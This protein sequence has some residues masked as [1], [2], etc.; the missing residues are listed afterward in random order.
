MLGQFKCAPWVTFNGD[1]VRTGRRALRA[2]IRRSREGPQLPRSGPEPPRYAEPS[3]PEAKTKL[4]LVC[5]RAP[6]EGVC[7]HA[8][9][10]VPRGPCPGPFSAAGP[11]PSPGFGLWT[12]RGVDNH[13]QPGLAKTWSWKGF[14]VI[15]KCFIIEIPFLI[16]NRNLLLRPH[17]QYSNRS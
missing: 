14:K 3:A 1:D 12:L 10:R 11:L 4:P 6:G 2:G 15:L 17:H 9:T 13:P 16:R 5:G 8:S 7:A